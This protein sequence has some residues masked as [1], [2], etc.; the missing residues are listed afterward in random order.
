MTSE[1]GSSAPRVERCTTAQILPLRLAVL[2]DGTP[3]LDANYSEDELPG[4]VH[5]AI[6]EQTE[7]ASTDGTFTNGVVIATSTW[8]PRPYPFDQAIPPA[9]A[10]QLKGM[11]VAKTA[12]GNGLGAALLAS[13]I[14]Q[15]AT[16]GAS[17]VWARA[18][19]SALYFYE[20]HGFEV[21]GE[22]FID[23]A[24]GLSHHIVV[25]WLQ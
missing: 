13:G 23:E 3:S 14:E 15:A 4:A 10:L 2:R 9:T 18:R 24:T 19:D 25:T 21:V 6:R 11:A 12:Q 22:Q 7:G 5:L 1:S 8:I 20:R 17:C 16:L